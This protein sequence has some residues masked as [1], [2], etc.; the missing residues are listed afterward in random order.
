[1]AGNGKYKMLD[2]TLKNIKNKTKI[3]IYNKVA[4]DQIQKIYNKA[5][6]LFLHHHVKIF[7]IYFWK[8]FPL[9]YQFVVPTKSQ[10]DQ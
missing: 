6:I 8:P 7:L 10:C 3:T 1:M 2:K 4:Y 5:D 9:A